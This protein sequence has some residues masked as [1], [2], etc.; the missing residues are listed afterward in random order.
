MKFFVDTADLKQIKEVN[1]W[2]P[3]D[4]VTT[5][6]TLVA[7][8][9]GKDHHGLIRSISRQVKGPISAE[10][11]SVKAKGMIQEG[12]TLAKIHPQ[13]AV[14]LPL[15]TAGLLACRALKK[16]KIT[17]NITLCFSALQ[18]LLA[19]R[20]GADFVSIF[21]GRLDDIGMDGMEV[22]SQVIEIFS[23]YQLKTQVLVASVR[24]TSHILTSAML[25]ADAVTIPPALFLK[26]IQ[27]PLTDKGLS[28]FLKSAG[29]KL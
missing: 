21:V 12:K 3:V 25:G 15:T 1:Q 13:V 16:E 23:L 22:V 24:H 17:V 7:D 4:G 11:L 8:Q 5:N 18:A 14:K 26:M 2:F 28:Q 19:A 9:K 10:V 27:N 29:R 6:P 20:A